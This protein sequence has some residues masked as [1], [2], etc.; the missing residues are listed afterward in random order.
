MSRALDVLLLLSVQ[1]ARLR[2]RRAAAEPGA[3]VALVRPARGKAMGF[4]YL[5]IGIGGA[6]V[7]LLS[8]AGRSAFGWRGALQAARRADHRARA[9]VRLFR[10]GRITADA[11]TSAQRRPGARPQRNR[12]PARREF[13]I[14]SVL[15]ARRRQHVLDRR[16]RRDEPAPE[17][18][19]QPRSAATRR[20]GRS[21]HFHWC[22]PSAS[23]D[24]CL[25]DGSPIACRRS[26]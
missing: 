6:I 23:P 10:P 24:D 2:V 22:S 26:R 14:A 18:V 12:W 1:R 13:S 16:G 20:A 11:P 4:A 25:W 3:A 21:H 5:G 17:A 15:P 7:P 8:A 9:A 19:S